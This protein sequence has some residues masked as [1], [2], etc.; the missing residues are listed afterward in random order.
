MS[1]ILKAIKH[2][3]D[4]GGKYAKT[5][6]GLGGKKYHSDIPSFQNGEKISGSKL[7]IQNCSPDLLDE[8]DLTYLKFEFFFLISSRASSSSG[9]SSDEPHVAIE[10]RTLGEKVKKA[11]VQ[12]FY[13]RNIKMMGWNGFGETEISQSSLD[14]E[15]IE[16]RVQTNV[17][18][19]RNKTFLRIHQ[20]STLLQDI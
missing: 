15:L 5:F 4:A 8:P 10:I 3:K 11:M 6:L 16:V 17:L 14:D 18:W 1:E 12:G 13:E 19:I 7:E 9:S 20:V 2:T